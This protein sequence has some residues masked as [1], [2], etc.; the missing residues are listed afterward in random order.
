MYKRQGLHT[1]KIKETD[2]LVALQTELTKLGGRVHI[3]HNSLHLEG[4]NK[5]N[6]NVRIGTYQDHRMAM[7]FAPIALKASVIIEEADV[8]SKSYPGFWEDLKT[9]NFTAI[10]I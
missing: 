8:V 4:S 1:L 9:I 3:T 10:E 7:A 2:R 5:I 6:K